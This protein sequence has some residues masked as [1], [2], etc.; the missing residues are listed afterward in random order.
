MNQVFTY[1]RSVDIAAPVETVFAFHCDPHNL[2]RITPSSM[3]VTLLH[4]EEMKP[5]AVV[6]LRVRPLPLVAQTWRMV[7]DEV[8]SPHRLTDRMEKGPFRQWIQRR[9]FSAIPMGTR[10]TDRVEYVLPFGTLGRLAGRLVVERI[11][12]SMFVYR[13]HRTKQMIEE[14][15]HDR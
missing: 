12:A 3:S 13:Q 10:L 4:W 5:G 14:V 15:S 7:F 9:I 11:V 1:E 6:E 2:Q 8:D